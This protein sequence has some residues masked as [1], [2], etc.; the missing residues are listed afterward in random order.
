[1]PIKVLFVDDDEPFLK[2][3]SEFIKREATD[4]NITTAVSAIEA[5]ETFTL[6]DFDAII[7]DY[8]MPHMDGLEFLEIVRK[9]DANIPFIIFTGRG[10]EEI[11]IRAL[12]LGASYYVIKGGDPKSQFAELIHIV[13]SSVGH[14]RE[15]TARMESEGLYQLVFENA[16]EG[17][18]LVHR[19]TR[20]MYSANSS[21]CKLTGYSKDEI[22]SLSLDDLHPP[23]YIELVKNAFTKSNDYRTLAGEDFPIIRKDGSIIYTDISS[24]RIQLSGEDYQLGIFRDVTERKKIEEQLILQKEE[25]SRFANTMA[26]DLRS[27]IHAIVNLTGLLENELDSQYVKEIADI[28]EKIESILKRS[29]ALADSGTVIGDKHPID[30]TEIIGDVI[31]MVLPKHVRVEYQNLPVINCDKA[32]ISQVIQNLLLNAHE[33]GKA[34]IIRISSTTG[35]NEVRI[36]ITNDGSRIPKEYQSL[37]FNNTFSTKEGGGLGLRIVKRIVDAHG[38]EISLESSLQTS[39]VISIPFNDIIIGKK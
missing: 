17:I 11:A 32:K 20:K 18:I 1:M 34:K 10:R 12:N 22:L 36:R 35:D 37:L 9:H 23:R 33:H 30:L 16:L 14:I 7:C 21:F 2:I 13:R 26:H 3:S 39:F 24:S 8:L 38:W 28:A 6:S 25:L 4:F 29:I 5:L 27:N 19:G 15:K 31:P